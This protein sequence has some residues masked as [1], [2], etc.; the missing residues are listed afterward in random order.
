MTLQQLKYVLEVA[1]QGSMNEAAKSLYIS[2]PSLSN[3]IKELE[4][5][6]SMTL[7]TRTNKGIS[8]SQEGRE[9]LRYARGVTEPFGRLEERYL[10]ASPE[11]KRFSVTTQ[12]YVFAI[13]AFTELIEEFGL[14]ENEYEYTFRETVLQK[15]VD[16]VKDFQSEIGILYMNPYNENIIRKMLKE[17][18]LCFHQL[19]RERSH[20]LMGSD[21][22]LARKKELVLRD[23]RKYPYISFEQGEYNS[24]YF[25]EEML[26]IS[27][28]KRNVKVNDRSSLFHLIRKLN[29]F[30]LCTRMLSPELYGKKIAARPLAVEEQ[31]TVGYITHNSAEL[32]EMAELY[33]EAMK[34]NVDSLL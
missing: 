20:V 31:V 25:S 34:R 2:Q 13:N 9:F 26:R 23:L 18:N 6:I 28:H 19:F 5:E 7:F 21:H 32:S 24:N 30:T 29:G 15:V 16:D 11:K 33:I 14:N 10:A 3:A 4:Q 8:I 27:D 22:P 17:N 12:H 1:R